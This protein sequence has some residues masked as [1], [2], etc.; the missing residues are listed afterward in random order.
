[1]TTLD[2]SVFRFPFL[3]FAFRLFVC[4]LRAA[5]KRG[6]VDFEGEMLLQVIILMKRYVSIFRIDF[7]IDLFL[8]LG[9]K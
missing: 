9:C 8:F 7:R 1:M 4:S 6:V 3:N 2:L 5:K